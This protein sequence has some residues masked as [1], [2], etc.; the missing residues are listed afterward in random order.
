MTWQ[1]IQHEVRVEFAE[2]S[3]TH[4][5]GA[6]HD[7]ITRHDPYLQAARILVARDC[8]GCGKAID[9]GDASVRYCTEQCRTRSYLPTR[10]DAYTQ[11]AK[12]NPRTRCAGRDDHGRKCRRY[13]PK[14]HGRCDEH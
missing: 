7:L 4:F 3:R 11:W 12:K 13:P 14:G 10:R 6:S 1:N 2:A 8:L 5:V 9:R